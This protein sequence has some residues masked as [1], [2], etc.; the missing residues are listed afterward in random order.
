M[1]QTKTK[2][3]CCF[4]V[5]WDGVEQTLDK[6]PR[7]L[8]ECKI[9]FTYPNKK[10]TPTDLAYKVNPTLLRKA[11]AYLLANNVR[12]YSKNLKLDD[13]MI[14]MIRDYRRKAI[15]AIGRDRGFSLDE[16]LNEDEFD[17]GK[18]LGLQEPE[19]VR[20][21]TVLNHSNVS[22]EEIP[23]VI[24][25]RYGSKGT[26]ANNAQANTQDNSTQ[27]GN[28]ININRSGGPLR[29][30]ENP[31]LLPNAF[32]S[33]YP[34]GEGGNYKN[35]TVPLTTSEYLKHTM[36]FGDPRFMRH[37]RYLF[38]M[39]NVKNLEKAYKT[40]AP[41]MNGRVM[42]SKVD[43]EE[44]DIT[45]EYLQKIGSTVCKNMILENVI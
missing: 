13:D 10:F 38:M 9:R 3:N 6:L 37:Y 42:M 18:A 21:S 7:A 17:I 29:Y 36:T 44:V 33:L 28:P 19:F 8:D 27:Q 39:C 31:D 20:Y 45:D 24:A 26:P 5:N 32:P 43:G 4:F 41:I 12:Y 16:V 14:N 2:G 34:D 23:E 35:F 22:S 40:I 30:H 15:E 25:Q 1:G 11:A